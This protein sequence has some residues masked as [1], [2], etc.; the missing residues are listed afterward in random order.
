MLIQLL[1]L[2]AGIS[3]RSENDTYNARTGRNSRSFHNA[4]SDPIAPE[5]SQAVTPERV[6]RFVSAPGM[7]TRTTGPHFHEDGG[8]RLQGGSLRAIDAPE[9][10]VPPIYGNFH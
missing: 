9:D 6:A 4:P 1:K 8:V 7:L 2:A 3:K 5:Y 10:D